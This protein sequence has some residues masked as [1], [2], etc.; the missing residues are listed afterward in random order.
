[1]DGLY[2]F[3]LINCNAFMSVSYLFS[4]PVN[5]L[6]FIGK[7]NQSNTRGWKE[8]RLWERR[9][10]SR[11]RSWPLGCVSFLLSMILCGSHQSNKRS[12]CSLYP[13]G[14]RIHNGHRVH[15]GDGY[16]S[17]ELTS[18]QDGQQAQVDSEEDNT[19]LLLLLIGNLC[20]HTYCF[21]APM[22]CG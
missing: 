17:L 10:E 5:H 4:K 15:E 18:I 1:M 6:A 2:P 13:Q 7:G 12:W 3:H 21:Q 9:S 11:S 19:R 20:T 14:T 16:C 22:L 8:R